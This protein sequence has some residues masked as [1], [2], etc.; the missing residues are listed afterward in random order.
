MQAPLIPLPQTKAVTACEDLWPGGYLA[1]IESECENDFVVELLGQ[2]SGW[3][4]TYLGATDLDQ[5]TEGD[6]EGTWTWIKTGGS[7]FWEGGDPTAGGAVVS[8]MYANFLDGEPNNAGTNGQDCLVIGESD[9][10]WR[11]QLCSKTSQFLCETAATEGGASITPAPTTLGSTI[12][13]SSTCDEGWTQTDDCFCYQV[14]NDLRTWL[15]ARAACSALRTGATLVSL[16][17]AALEFKILELFGGFSSDTLND[18]SANGGLGANGYWTGGNDLTNLANDDIITSDDT[19]FKW[20]FDQDV[21]WRRDTSEAVYC[22]EVDGKYSNWLYISDTNAQPN[23]KK[24]E[25]NCVKMKFV[26]DDSGNLEKA[27]WD[28]IDCEKKPIKSVCQYSVL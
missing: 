5:D 3:E 16:T 14:Q 25:Q 17:S 24:E 2:T 28:D 10:E 7:T 19:E 26:A 13:C 8:G 11:D 20:D 15:E 27:G 4:Q 22:C 6:T 23:H 18:A 9:G 1:S 21:F 12:A